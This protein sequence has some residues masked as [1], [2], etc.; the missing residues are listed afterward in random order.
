M[1]DKTNQSLVDRQQVI[2]RKNR[3]L[4]FNKI[5]ADIAKIPTEMFHF[6]NVYSI[7]VMYRTTVDG[8]RE[9]DEAWVLKFDLPIV[10]PSISQKIDPQLYIE[11]AE[12]CNDIIA[13]RKERQE[14]INFLKETTNKYSGSL[15]LRKIW[16]EALHRFLPAEPVKQPKS[17]RK[18]AKLTNP[19]PVTPGFISTRLTQ[20]LLEG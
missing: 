15:Q 3:D 8:E 13:F 19:D 5:R 10:N 4:F 2:L 18:K 16:P 1:Y 14:L 9:I 12:L 11:A 7:A 6:S 17:T 20:N